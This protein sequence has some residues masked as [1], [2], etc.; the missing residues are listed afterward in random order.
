MKR[1]RVAAIA[2]LLA[3]TTAACGDD[4]EPN[5]APPEPSPS[6]SEVQTSEPPSE[7]PEALS[8]EDTVRA[9]VEAR[10]TTVQ[11]GD[12][13]EVYAL[14]TSGCETCRNSVEPVR[15]VYAAGGRYETSGWRLKDVAKTPKYDRTGE[16]IA[17]VVFDSGRTFPD[18]NSD[19]ISYPEEKHV[20]LFRLADSQ[21]VLGVKF[22]G[23]IP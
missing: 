10:N 21:G 12:T 17:A 16:V 9:W 8:P 14:S 2:T 20:M 3:L 1:T 19:P 11:T 4:P 7:P 5:F 15:K 23:Y 22:V 18:A 6:P 13:D